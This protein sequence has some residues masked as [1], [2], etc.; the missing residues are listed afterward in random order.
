[1]DTENFSHTQLNLLALLLFHEQD[2]KLV[3]HSAAI[4]S[5][6]GDGAILNLVKKAYTYID[7]YTKPPKKDSYSLIEEINLS[8]ESMENLLIVVQR[9]ELLHAEGINTQATLDRLDKF[10]K[11][12]AY[13]KMVSDGIPLLER[14]NVADFESLIRTA[15]KTTLQTFKPGSKLKDFVETLAEVDLE[16]QESNRILL[17]IKELDDY[18]MHP[19]RGT[20]SIFLAPMGRGKSW[21]LSYVAKRGL[22]FGK[23]VLHVSLEMD[24]KSINLRYLQSLYSVRTQKSP[25]HQRIKVVASGGYDYRQELNR[26][27]IYD[28]LGEIRDNVN[29]DDQILKNLIVKQLPTGLTSLAAVEGY[30]DSL[31]IHNNFTPDVLI[32][33]YADLLRLDKGDRWDMLEKLINE[34]RGL[35]VERNMILVTASQTNRGGILNNTNEKDEID[36]TDVAG[37]WGKTFGADFILG[38]SQKPL[39]KQLGLARLNVIKNRT[40]HSGFTIA[41]SQ[42]YSI[43]QFIMP[44]CSQDLSNPTHRDGYKEILKKHQTAAK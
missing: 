11:I 12:N 28:C 1:M 40:G 20:I 36:E 10:Q 41:I 4:E 6:V 7:T 25:P 22:L 16:A 37:S 44:G 42:D 35:A 30:I 32:L 17:G 24:E 14:G 38:Y 19:M 5:W 8:A 29:R 27:L 21:W 33:D 34:L 15:N 26:P 31:E 23:K 43:G 2:Y 13:K 3:R 9:A 18:E 39:E